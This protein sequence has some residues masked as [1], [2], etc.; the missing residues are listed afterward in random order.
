MAFKRS[1]SIEAFCVS[2]ITIVTF[3]P[4]KNN[5]SNSD[6]KINPLSLSNTH[7]CTLASKP[8]FK[9]CLNVVQ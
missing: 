4:F 8:L 9:S 2:N 5:Y 1:P 7:I 6:G 3:G